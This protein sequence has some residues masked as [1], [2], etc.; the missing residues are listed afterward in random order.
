MAENWDADPAHLSPKTCLRIL[1]VDD[2]AIIAL[3]SVDMLEE[4]GHAVVAAYSGAEALTL[5]QSAA[6]FDLLITDLSMPRMNGR[7]L[8]TAARQLFPDLP[9]LLA[10]GHVEQPDERGLTLPC[11]SKPYSYDKLQAAIE[12]VSMGRAD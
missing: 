9:I 11:L 1:F 6:R 2:E 5:L 12:R 4:M 10:T 8:A 3:S 7:Q